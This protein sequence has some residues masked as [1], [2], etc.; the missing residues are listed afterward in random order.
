MNYI[1]IGVLAISAIGVILWVV[2]P[3][4]IKTAFLIARVTPYER[5][6]P[7][8][9]SILIIGDSTGYGTG[10]LRGTESIAG[11]I[12]ADFPTYS[13]ENRSVNGRT[14]EEA[15]PVA[16]AVTGEYAL[17]LL[18]LGGNDILTARDPA[19]VERALRTLT[20]ILSAHTEHIVMIST[21]NVG[22]ASEFSPEKATQYE[23]I[24]REF[25]EMF[26]RVAADTPLTYVDL[27]LEPEND[28][29]IVN[30]ETYLAIDGLHPSSAGYALWYQELHPTLETALQ[31]KNE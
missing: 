20:Q 29:F 17:V 28:P 11:R 30:P 31:Q 3:Y 19:D 23:A 14:V 25:R 18:Q 16:E 6:I 9:P 13:I 2:G 15:L 7:D 26:E 8:A 12:A 1:L 22:G 10:A 21:G 27:F 5:H 24:T 4:S